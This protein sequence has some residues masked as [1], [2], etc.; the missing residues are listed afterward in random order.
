MSDWTE[1]QYNKDLPD[2]VFGE[3]KQVYKASIKILDRKPAKQFLLC[4]VGTVGAGKTTIVKPLSEKLG[5]ARV[6]T[7]EIR[8]VLKSGGYNFE[9][10]RD[11]SF[12]ILKELI[13]E[14]Y[15][16]AVDANCGTPGG[17]SK[18]KEA[19][20]KYH[21]IPVWIRINPPE[22]FIINKLKNYKHTWLF[23]DGEEAVAN[24]FR[25]KEKYGDF[26][27]LDLP[28]VYEFDTSRPDLNKQIEEAVGLIKEYLKWTKSN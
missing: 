14:G 20:G 24:Y 16:V 15:S 2:D 4:P 25:Y 18:V 10:V 5:L 8:Q 22:E 11:I 19:S 23:K 17:I 3:I 13:E 12:E 21:T 1:A 28:Y 9:K 26:S 6:S 7:D 27:N